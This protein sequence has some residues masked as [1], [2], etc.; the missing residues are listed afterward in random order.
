MKTQQLGF[1]LIEVVYS[2]SVT[3]VLISLTLPL[4]QV[5]YVSEVTNPDGAH[6]F[7]VELFYTQLNNEIRESKY[8]SN[9]ESVLTLRKGTGE[10]VTYEPYKKVL[11][12]RVNGAGHEV[13]LQNINFVKFQKVEHGISVIVVD[14]LYQVYERRLSFSTYSNGGIP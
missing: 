8:I 13:V 1:T 2:I 12:R 7:E 10:L 4:F 11:R 3:L 5:F 9:T 14:L 6:L